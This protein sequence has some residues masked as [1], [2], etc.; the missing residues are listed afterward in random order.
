MI[1]GIIFYMFFTLVVENTRQ[2]LLKP[3]PLWN[4]WPHIA[5]GTRDSLCS[6]QRGLTE[7]P[8][9]WAKLLEDCLGE[10]SLA[11]DK[12]HQQR[13]FFSSSVSICTELDHE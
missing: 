4:D 13:R 9:I 1:Y 3:F 5:S 12:Q 8:Q 2:L 6:L 7:I 11:N 10:N